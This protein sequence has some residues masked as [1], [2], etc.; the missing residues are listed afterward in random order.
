MEKIPLSVPY[1][2]GN[3]WDYIKECLDTNWVSS[4]GK[5][6]DKFEEKLSNY[7][8]TEYGV[9]CVN[10]TATIHTALKVLGVG[11]GD[12][13]LVPSLTFIASVNPI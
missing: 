13:V 1:I 4:K 6:V 12:K 10:G 5:Y 11:P 7:V 2:N 8:N 3:E 9:A